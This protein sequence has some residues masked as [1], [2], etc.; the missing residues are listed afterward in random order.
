MATKALHSREDQWLRLGEDSGSF[1]SLPSYR[2][3]SSSNDSERQAG[4]LKQIGRRGDSNYSLPNS[5]E[6][7]CRFMLMLSGL[8][9][10]FDSKFRTKS[11]SLNQFICSFHRWDCAQ[12]H[13]FWW[14]FRLKSPIILLKMWISAIKQPDSEHNQID[15]V[16]LFPI[17]AFSTFPFPRKPQWTILLVEMGWVWSENERKLGVEKKLG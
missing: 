17:P 15:E 5:N 6:R 14:G 4:Q 7:V 13:S 9:P 3:V 11:S 12:R 16:I 2:R 8:R 1:P 10:F